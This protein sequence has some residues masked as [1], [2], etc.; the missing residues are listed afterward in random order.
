MK[1]VQQTIPSL[2]SPTWIEPL[3]RVCGSVAHPPVVMT[4]CLANGRRL[5]FLRSK[6]CELLSV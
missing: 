3:E 5:P 6:R 4:D 1:I 2:G